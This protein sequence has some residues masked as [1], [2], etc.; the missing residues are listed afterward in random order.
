MSSAQ[1]SLRFAQGH[2]EPGTSRRRCESTPLFVRRTEKSKCCRP[3]AETMDG[4]REAGD[5]RRSMRVGDV[6]FAGGPPARREPNQ[7]FYW[8][9]LEKDGTLTAFGAGEAV[10][11]ATAM[12]MM[13]RQI[14]QWQ[15]L[16]G[17]KT[18]EG[19]ILK[20][21]F[22]LARDRKWIERSPLLALLESI[23]ADRVEL[24]AYRHRDAAESGRSPAI[25]AP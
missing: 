5:G 17:K 24:A 1:V 19:E 15:G 10:V 12:E 20:E 16:L 3:A 4:L 2:R 9:R 8:R 14:R 21:A 13:R 7:L 23:G 18:L 11:P 6:G 22:D 25:R